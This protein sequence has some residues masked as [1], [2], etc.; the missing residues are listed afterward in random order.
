MSA[1]LKRFYATTVG[2]SLKHCDTHHDEQVSNLVLKAGVCLGE[3][4]IG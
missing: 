1:R 3:V 4:D 2:R